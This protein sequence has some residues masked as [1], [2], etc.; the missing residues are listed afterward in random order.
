M[1]A[2]GLLAIALLFMISTVSAGFF[3]SYQ[4]DNFYFE[5]SKGNNYHYSATPYSYNYDGWYY[6]DYPYRVYSYG[7]YHYF[8]P[9]W[10]T[11]DDGFV[12]YP[13]SNY[14][15]YYGPDYYYYNNYWNYYPGWIDSYAPSYYGA[16][17]YPPTVYDT[18][19]APQGNY[20]IGN[21]T[22]TGQNYHPTVRTDCG[23]TSL[24]V[25]NVT[26]NSGTERSVVFYVNN[27]SS[28]DM[29]LEN[30]YIY[31]DG[32][33]VDIS[34][35]RHDGVVRSNSTE[36]IE[37]Y[38]S[39]EPYVTSQARRATINVTGTFRDG[40]RC[41]GS[42]L[43]RDFYVNVNG[44]SNVRPYVQ[45]CVNG[46][47]AYCNSQGST[48]FNV[49]RDSFQSQQE[50]V[51]VTPTPVHVEELPETIVTYYEEPQIP[52]AN[53]SSLSIGEENFV[54]EANDDKTAYFTFRNYSTEN[55]HIDNIEAVDYSPDFGIEAYRELSTVYSGQTTAI[56][57]R[58]HGSD[59]EEDSTGSAYITI[60]GHFNSGMNC[61]LSSDTFYVRVN[62]LE[63]EPG[64][65]Q[66][67]LYNPA[68]VKVKGKAGFVSF[69]VDNPSNEVITVKVYSNDVLV[70]P[71]EFTISPK[72][73]SERIVTINGLDEDGTIFFD[74]K[75]DDREYLQKYTNVIQVAS[76]PFRPEPQT[77][78]VH[79]PIDGGNEQVE[80]DNSFLATGFSFLS[81]NGLLL[82]IIL[83]ILLIGIFLV[84][85]E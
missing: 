11:F 42:D 33:D 67:K 76:E 55:F 43:E 27:Y 10:Y 82:G 17:Y 2:W 31:V 52:T 61:A 1:K 7:D 63:N 69:E 65:D 54:V 45:D 73:L 56:K 23:E 48:S 79:I 83:L 38:L 80:P 26:I 62:G 24:N 74:V 15:S 37:F 8:E 78:E 39:A 72:T 44:V 36:R 21:A 28:M 46:S 18:Y 57:V 40:V 66:V 77:V 30:V 20:A 53:C 75:A 34:N 16:Y 47:T 13:Y 22:L 6:F 71:K 29:D 4:S 49:A 41:T 60:N 58:A 14:Y 12:N 85:R 64:L 81:D 19:Y 68:E 35:I 25:N 50:W 9:G 5:I 3:L 32:F 51:E 84:S 70:S 59:P